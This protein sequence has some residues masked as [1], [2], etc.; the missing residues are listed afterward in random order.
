M[1]E[2]LGVVKNTPV[3][4]R[5]AELQTTRQMAGQQY[6]NRDDK[7][8]RSPRKLSSTS[9]LIREKPRAR[10]EALKNTP[11]SALAKRLKLQPF[12]SCQVV[13][14]RPLKTAFSFHL[15]VDI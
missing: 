7:R 14:V 15:I 13:T 2:Y 10:I 8:E 3:K 11:E 9:A 12:H 4:E 6:A 1:A 5:P